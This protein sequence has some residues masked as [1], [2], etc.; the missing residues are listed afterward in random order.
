MK[1]AVPDWCWYA[2]EAAAV[3]RITE[4]A[5]WCGSATLSSA[6]TMLR[7][8]SVSAGSRTLT[9]IGVT[10]NGRPS[11]GAGFVTIKVGLP[12][13]RV[14]PSVPAP[15][16]HGFPA[17]GRAG[18]RPRQ[19]GGRARLPA[20]FR[21]LAVSCQ[22]GGSAL[23]KGARLDRLLAVRQRAAA[24]SPVRRLVVGAGGGR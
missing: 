13:A 15:S 9:G 4:P 24:T 5:A 23:G 10:A 14:A 20:G 6:P 1:R 22:L 17:T 12:T 11:R 19:S 8:A 3:W 16:R 18:R 7:C 2:S 21:A